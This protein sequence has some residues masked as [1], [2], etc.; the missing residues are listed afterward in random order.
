MSIETAAAITRIFGPCRI[1]QWNARDPNLLHELLLMGCD[2]HAVG[3]GAFAHPRWISRC[4]DTRVPPKPIAVVEIA[5]GQETLVLIETLA[6]LD[7]LQG[8][9]LIGPDVAGLRRPLENRLFER[10]WRRHPA[11]LATSD[12]ER[13]QDDVLPRHAVYQRIPAEAASRWPVETLLGERN[14]HMDMLRES[15]SRADAHVVR[16]ALAASLVRP[17]D[18]VLDCA[19]GLGYGSAVIAATS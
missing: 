9:F 2:A 15:G 16:Y 10:G 3:R 6:A 1:V 8:L 19:C 17:G 7:H 13:M 14:L 4:S 12:Y 11:A 18:I 5:A